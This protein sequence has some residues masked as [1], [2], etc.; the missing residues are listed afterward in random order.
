MTIC[1]ASIHQYSILIIELDVATVGL[2][3]ALSKAPV[4]GDGTL[5]NQNKGNITDTTYF[6]LSGTS[7]A[8]PMV[9]GAAA[10]LLRQNPAL[11]PDQVKA[12]LMKTAYKTFPT[13][14]VATD[15]LNLVGRCV[16]QYCLLLVPAVIRQP[17]Q[18]VGSIRGEVTVCH[19]TL[20]Y[21]S[22]L[23]IFIYHLH[24]LL[25]RYPNCA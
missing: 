14:S 1:R 7:M 18:C 2:R 20:A 12:R 9:S 24:E 22:E 3:P 10:L 17:R 8:T 6:V 21:P 13:T 5:P 4:R 11:T 15:P 23:P 25:Q 19:S 16:L